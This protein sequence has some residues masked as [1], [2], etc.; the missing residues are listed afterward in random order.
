MGFLEPS[1]LMLLHNFVVFALMAMKLGEVIEL[2]V[3]YTTVKY[4]CEAM[5]QNFCDLFMIRKGQNFR[6]L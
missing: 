2:D 4:F 1:V 3:F 6:Y 5:R